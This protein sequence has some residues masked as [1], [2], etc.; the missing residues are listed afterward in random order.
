MESKMGWAM[1]VESDD[2]I[3]IHYDE[4][5]VARGAG[6]FPMSAE[7]MIDL[8]GLVSGVMTKIRG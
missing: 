5:A 6:E 7:N 2:L 4:P 3:A 8:M 1:V